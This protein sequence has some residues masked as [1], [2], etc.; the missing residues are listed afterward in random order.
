[1]LADA[2]KRFA[3][4]E[5]VA[6]ILEAMTALA[7]SRSRE[8]MMK[9]ARYSSSRLSSR[10]AAKD[11]VAFSLVADAGPAYLRRKRQQGK[12]EV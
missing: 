8:R 12:G 3:G 9:E 1:M 11:E 6:G 10:L 7:Q 5:W 4:N 2:R